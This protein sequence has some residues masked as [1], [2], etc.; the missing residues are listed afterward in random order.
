MKNTFFSGL[1]LLCLLLAGCSGK[2]QAAN[3][4]KIA[5]NTVDSVTN[6]RDT[7]KSVTVDNTELPEVLQNNQAIKEYFETY[8]QIIVEYATTLQE[9]SEANKK[10]IAKNEKGENA[11]AVDAVLVLSQVAALT[12]KIAPMVQKMEDLEKTSKILKKNMT[13]EEAKAFSEMSNKLVLRLRE[14]QKKK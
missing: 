12:A 5:E 13:T 4:E 9:M 3:T 2:K 7:Q 14:L 1:L 11:D 8:E 10:M 6:I